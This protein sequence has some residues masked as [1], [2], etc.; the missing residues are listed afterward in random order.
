[1]K[2]HPQIVQ[3]FAWLASEVG[4]S[5][6]MALVSL[7]VDN[8]VVIEK[9]SGKLEFAKKLGVKHLLNPDYC[10]IRTEV[11]KR[12]PSGV[13]YCIECAGHIKTIEMGFDLIR[14]CGGKL[15]FA[16]H[17][18]ENEMISLSPHDL[19]SGKKIQGSWGGHCEPDR[20]IPKF[21]EMFLN[22]GM[23]MAEMVGKSYSLDAINLALADL[24]KGNV[25]RP[26]IE[27]DQH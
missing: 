14:N 3:A 10:D 1:M 17:P 16:S 21:S 25:M 5:A 8:I 15:I 26:I 9:S 6:L 7:G 18:P 23:P 11:T 22:A 24:E 12:Y 13:D 20:D 2:L 27:F 4:I 19:I